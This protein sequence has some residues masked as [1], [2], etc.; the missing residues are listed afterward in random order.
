[1]KITNYTDLNIIDNDPDV[2]DIDHLM[3]CVSY[4]S[5][6]LDH[7]Y[8]LIINKDESIEIHKEDNIL[9]TVIDDKTGDIIKHE[10]IN[11]NHENLKI[12]FCTGY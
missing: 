5:R 1:M 7:G 3:E 11:K 4:L 6:R 8:L 10:F 12:I 2:L 9:N